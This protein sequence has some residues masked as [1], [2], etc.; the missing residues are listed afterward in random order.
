MRLL[1][2]NTPEYWA[3]EK[4]RQ[5]F[6]PE[7]RDF[8]KNLIE[9]K[10]VWLE[11]DP[12]ASNEDK[13]HRWL[14]YVYYER[15][16]VGVP[17]NKEKVNLSEQL[18]KEGYAEAE[19]YFPYGREADFKNLAETAKQKGLGLWNEQ[20]CPGASE[21]GLVKPSARVVENQH[22]T[23]V[24]YKQDKIFYADYSPYIIKDDI[25]V[26]DG[27][28]L[29]IEPGAILKFDSSK[30]IRVYKG[31]LRAIASENKPIIFT[32]LKDDEAGE[33][34]NNNGDNSQPNQ[35]DWRG[36]LLDASARNNLFFDYVTLRYAGDNNYP[37]LKANK[38]SLVNIQHS[39]IYQNAGGLHFSEADVD[40]SFSNIFDNFD[41]KLSIKRDV[42]Q[43]GTL[44]SPAV[45]AINNWWGSASGPFSL[46]FNPDGKGTPVN[47]RVDFNP[48]LTQKFEIAPEVPSAKL[49][50]VII[51]PGIMGS[52]Q[53]KGEWKIDPIFHTYNNLY[54]ALRQAGYEPEKT[55][56]TFPYQWRQINEITARELKDKIAEVK[57]ICVCSKV[58]L[59]AHSMGG[60]AARYYIQTDDL[61]GDDV[62][63]L[64][65]LAVPHLGS[66]KA[67]LAWEGG[68]LGIK[69]TDKLK[70][71]IF[72]FEAVKNGYFSLQEYVY[73]KI[74]STE[75]LLPV[76]DY[77]KDKNNGVLRAYPNKY[78]VN[79][80][81]ET[82]N[83]NLESLSVVS[84][85]NYFAD[86][87]SNN[88]YTYYYVDK[89]SGISR[90]WQHGE[91]SRLEELK[92][93]GDVELGAGDD[94]VPI[95]S[96]KWLEGLKS[97]EIDSDH[98]KI[99]TNA[100]NEIIKE[101]TGEESS[102]FVNDSIVE[103]YLFVR[104]YSPIDFLVVSPSGQT[105]G[106][107][108]DIGEIENQIT[109]SFYSGF[110][111]DLEFAVIPN[112][113]AGDYQIEIIGTDMGDY[114]VVA[115]FINS[116]IENETSFTGAT[117][118]GQ[119]TQLA[120]ALKDSQVTLDK[121][122]EAELTEP[123]V[124]NQQPTESESSETDSPQQNPTDT[125]DSVANLSSQPKL[126][127]T[128]QATDTADNI[129][130]T[131]ENETN[132]EESISLNF[133]TSAKP[134]NEVLSVQNKQDFSNIT[135]RNLGDVSAVEQEPEL[136]QIEPETA[137]GNLAA[138][139]IKALS[140]EQNK[141]KSE[142]LGWIKADKTILILFGLLGSIA[143]TYGW[144]WARHNKSSY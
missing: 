115:T 8:V 6:G 47:G 36:I 82:I 95:F 94:T 89:G 27:A 39:Q 19:D 91:V 130:E 51:I 3:I 30:R 10:T 97:V 5:C 119:R 57:K 108:P 112:P 100:Q 52:W 67:Y 1:G 34:S 121:P 42:S 4:S 22:S 98:T 138:G 86:N 72:Q 53:V 120:L 83:T 103:N 84:I 136:N 137:T 142:G 92:E 101:L 48:W 122:A 129:E 110:D 77:L 43:S 76:F 116:Q 40:I 128:S 70:K 140:I 69:Q 132:L 134:L 29:T 126:N 99:V 111:T 55:V 23:Y 105:L 123:V 38:L 58:D 56:F 131:N 31:S 14:R 9:A 127:E 87:K 143:I 68:E 74:K 46:L 80:F 61:Y 2:I 75:Q 17:G 114:Q 44:L 102:I 85:K 60:L 18:L 37:A 32:S 125:T 65:F 113:E 64:I 66:P 71:Y 90:K 45:K 139:S 28:S 141:V 63:Q 118:N 49:D 133:T 81:L 26:S 35:N 109:G 104:V 12:L 93:G 135:N 79:N 54:Q 107:N 62:D 21:H 41:P 96:A 15:Y 59:I 144:F 73:D 25:H 50:P 78:P 13:Y 33:D 16:K 24:S 106:K 88:T 124:Q 117:T 20:D 7:A 11:T